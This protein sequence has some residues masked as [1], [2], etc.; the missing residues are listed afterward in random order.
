MISLYARSEWDIDSLI[1]TTRIYS[2]DIGMSFRLH[3]CS[4]MVTKNGKVAR[5]KG[6]ALPVGNIIDIKNSF[7]CLGIPLVNWNHEEAASKATTT[8]FLFILYLT[9]KKNIY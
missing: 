7:K 3:K 9:R 8:K 4:W 6:T 5:T 1:H 2:S